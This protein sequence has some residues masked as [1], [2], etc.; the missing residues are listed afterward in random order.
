MDR[1]KSTARKK[2][3]H[4]ESQRGEDKRWRSSEREEVRTEKMQVRDKVGKSRNTVV[5]M[6]V[7]RRVDK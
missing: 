5:P 6:F 7:A 3:R 1:W 2:L 4:G